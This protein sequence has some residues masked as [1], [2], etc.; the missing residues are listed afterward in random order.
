MLFLTLAYHLLVLTGFVDSVIQQVREEHRMKSQNFG[1]IVLPVLKVIDVK[2]KLIIVKAIHARK[3]L[4]CV[5]T[6]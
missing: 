5:L 3:M 2:Y 4:L 1:V 6:Q